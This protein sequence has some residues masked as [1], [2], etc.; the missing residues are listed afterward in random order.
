MHKGCI[1][2]SIIRRNHVD[3]GHDGHVLPVIIKFAPNH[4]FRLKPS[5][6]HGAHPSDGFTNPAVHHENRRKNSRGR[7]RLTQSDHDIQRLEKCDSEDRSK[8]QAKSASSEH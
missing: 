1:L 6:Y 7:G 8:T 5:G 3:Y 4:W 2:C